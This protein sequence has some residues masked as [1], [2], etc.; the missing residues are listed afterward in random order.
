MRGNVVFLSQVVLFPTK[1]SQRQQNVSLPLSIVIKTSG[2]V[3]IASE[4]GFPL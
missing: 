2:C 4:Q 3:F 1:K